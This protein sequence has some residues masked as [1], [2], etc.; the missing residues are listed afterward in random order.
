MNF[1]P[2]IDQ[3]LEEYLEAVNLERSAMA[4]ETVFI[5]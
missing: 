4:A 1:Q 3:D 5:G 2:M